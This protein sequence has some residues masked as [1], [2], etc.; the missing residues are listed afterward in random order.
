MNDESPNHE[1]T[2]P[3]IAPLKLQDKPIF[4]D[5]LVF[6]LSTSDCHLLLSYLSKNT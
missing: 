1:L 3:I 6:T 2:I 5:E 4:G